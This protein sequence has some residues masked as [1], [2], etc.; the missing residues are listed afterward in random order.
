MVLVQGRQIDHR[1]RRIQKQTHTNIKSYRQ[2]SLKIIWGTESY[3]ITDNMK[4]V[5]HT[6]KMKLIPYIIP[7]TKLIPNGKQT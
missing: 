6:E 3:S 5:A 2:S 1:T 4:T 7:Y